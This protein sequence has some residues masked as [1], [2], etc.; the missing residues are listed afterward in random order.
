MINNQD[1]KNKE[2]LNGLVERICDIDSKGEKITKIRAE[3]NSNMTL[4]PCSK[5]YRANVA[6]VLLDSLAD[7]KSYSR[8]IEEN[9]IGAEDYR[10]Q[11][12]D[13]R[14][15]VALPKNLFKTDAEYYDHYLNG[16]LDRDEKNQTSI[17]NITHCLRSFDFH[18]YILTHFTSY[19]LDPY[20]IHSAIA[21]LCSAI[22]E[23]LVTVACNYAGVPERPGFTEDE[24]RTLEDQGI[25][26]SYDK[27]GKLLLSF[28]QSDG[29]ENGTHETGEWQALTFGSFSIR[30]GN[31]DTPISLRDKLNKISRQN[32]KNKT[33]RISGWLSSK[34]DR[35]LYDFTVKLQ[36]FGNAFIKNN[37]GDPYPCDDYESWFDRIRKLRNQIHLRAV[38]GP[39]KRAENYIDL[40]TIEEL[41][42]F[43]HVTREAL[44]LYRENQESNG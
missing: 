37:T 15:L 22:E 19:K 11:R 36:E 34:R 1:E 13:E 40:K 25:S 6:T 23:L 14:C 5:K 43:F 35:S 21:D 20:V 16:I 4:E 31:G 44:K 7:L 10:K 32:N 12:E 26:Y 3:Y 9:Y 39:L 30:G 24:E 27:D 29:D 17:T 41:C 28:Q 33:N 42:M 18:M 8:I 2:L 38:G